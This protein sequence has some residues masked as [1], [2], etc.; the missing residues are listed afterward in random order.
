MANDYERDAVRVAQAARIRE[1]EAQLHEADCACIFPIAWRIL[2]A[3]KPDAPI[4]IEGTSEEQRRQM[5]IRYSYV[6]GAELVEELRR[7][8][9]EYDPERTRGQEQY[10]E[11]AKRFK[12]TRPPQLLPRKNKMEAYN[13]GRR[14]REENPTAERR[15]INRKVRGVRKHFGSL[16]AEHFL[17]GVRDF[18]KE[19]N[20]AGKNTYFAKGEAGGKSTHR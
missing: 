8:L 12:I 13:E 16:V 11:E 10:T 2:N 4:T 7:W 9:T 5:G 17:D 19:H 3:L 6:G 1:L 18:I 15:S 14:W 20:H